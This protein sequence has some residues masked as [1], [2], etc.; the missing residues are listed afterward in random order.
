MFYIISLVILVIALLG[1]GWEAQPEI[2]KATRSKIPAER[3]AGD[4]PGSC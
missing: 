2:G 3:K 1:T 4:L